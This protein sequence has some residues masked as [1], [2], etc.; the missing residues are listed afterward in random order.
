MARSRSIA[1]ALSVSTQDHSMGREDAPVTLIEY[2]DY[3]C[4]YCGE[5]ERALQLVR[6]RAGSN[7][8]F[9]FRNFPLVESH[10]HAMQ[11]AEAAES[12]GQQG[13]FWEMHD[14]LY[15][16]QRK[17]RQEDL[18]RYAETIGLDVDRFDRDLTSHSIR[19][20]IQQDVESGE[21]S[22]VEGTPWFF[23]NGRQYEGGWEPADLLEAIQS[24]LKR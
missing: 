9:V 15:R 11:A 18:S 20:R 16:N 1:L 13:K 19:P 17:L 10:P 24:E 8:R 4:P 5:A 6:E 3:E 14:M 2:G 21:A 22:G 7:L 12:A 23:I